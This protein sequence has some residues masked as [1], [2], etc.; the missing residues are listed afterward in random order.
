MLLKQFTLCNGV[1]NWHQEVCD[2]QANL[3]EGKIPDVAPVLFTKSFPL[4]LLD[5]ILIKL[6]CKRDWPLFGWQVRFSPL[7]GFLHRL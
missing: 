7:E 2:S 5:F 6:F 1:K 3:T 4:L